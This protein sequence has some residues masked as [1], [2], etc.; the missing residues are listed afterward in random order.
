[1]MFRLS[2]Y[3]NRLAFAAMRL[4]LACIWDQTKRNNDLLEWEYGHAEFILTTIP[5][6]AKEC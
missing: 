2:R 3:W 1:M 5:K 4:C 6:K